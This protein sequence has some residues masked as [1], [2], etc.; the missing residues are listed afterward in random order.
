MRGVVDARV[1]AHALHVGREDLQR[2]VVAARLQPRLDEA[3][4]DRVLPRAVSADR[5]HTAVREGRVKA[6]AMHA[7]KPPANGLHAEQRQSHV[8]YTS[9]ITPSQPT[10]S[11]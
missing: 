4:V 11:L 1:G 9:R 2:D 6:H 5:Q 3:Q 10:P 8:G 7:Y